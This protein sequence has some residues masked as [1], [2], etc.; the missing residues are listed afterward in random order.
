MAERYQRKPHQQDL[1]GIK[2][3]NIILFV[4][5]IVVIVLIFAEAA[6][7]REEK[8]DVSA[9][10][11]VSQEYDAQIHFIDVGE[12]DCSLII[13]D[14]STVLIDGGENNK[15]DVVLEYLESLNID[16]LDMLIATHPHSDHIGGLDTVINAIEVSSLIMPEL[17]DEIVPSTKT[18]TDFLTAI[19]ENNVPASYAAAGDEFVFGKGVFTIVSPQE[20]AEFDDLNNCSLVVMFSYDGVDVLF[21]GDMEKEAETAAL[22]GKIAL[23]ADILKVAHHGSKTSTSA[24][25]YNEVNPDFCIISLG[26]DNQYGFPHEKTLT[27]IAKNGA[28]VYRTDKDGSVC[29][30]INN[31]QISVQTSKAY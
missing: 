11:A 28:K 8:A 24:D 13:S 2:R 1:K 30:S 21:T 16:K 31:S 22:E 20:N 14:E 10:T 4:S 26:E 23:K 19:D 29:I 17:P 18:Y 7:L 27:T 3:L 6:R 12:G 9:N 25:F 5:I 15:G